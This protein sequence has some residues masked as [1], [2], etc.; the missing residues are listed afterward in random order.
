MVFC[1]HNQLA[2]LSERVARMD[3]VERT[4]FIP[5]FNPEVEILLLQLLQARESVS[6]PL[7]FVVE[8]MPTF[9]LSRMAMF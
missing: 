9:L 7:S 2:G 5:F 3:P 4:S 6:S 8:G 1:G